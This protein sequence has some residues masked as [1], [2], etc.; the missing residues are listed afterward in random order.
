MITTIKTDT[1]KTIKGG[2]FRAH[3]Q[4]T[5]WIGDYASMADAKRA[6]QIAN[7]NGATERQ[8]GIYD[9]GVNADEATHFAA[10]D[11]IFGPESMVDDGDI[12]GTILPGE[13]YNVMG[14]FPVRIK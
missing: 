11:T 1:I 6:L 10:V 5:F 2:K 9:G 13:K 3:R 8:R 12:A 4:A 7:S 14:G